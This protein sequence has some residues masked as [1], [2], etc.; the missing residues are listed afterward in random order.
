M[1]R[2]LSE[3]AFTALI[4]LQAEM[5]TQTSRHF[6]ARSTPTLNP[7]RETDEE[8]LSDCDQHHFI[9]VS[10]R[11]SNLERDEECASFHLGA[12]HIYRRTIRTTGLRQRRNLEMKRRPRLTRGD[13]ENRWWRL[14]AAY[15]E[16]SGNEFSLIAHKGCASHF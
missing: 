8:V 9:T 5:P 16:T 10:G 4:R 11:L 2:R 7:G 12:A 3:R 13:S 1:T 6:S 15:I 14:V